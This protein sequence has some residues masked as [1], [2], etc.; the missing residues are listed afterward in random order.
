M[1]SNKNGGFGVLVRWRLA[2]AVVLLSALSAATCEFA[3]AQ[4]TYTVTDLGTLGGTFGAANGINNKGWVDGMANLPGDANH[5][6]L[7]WVQGLKIDLGTLGGPNSM[8]GLGPNMNGKIVGLAE[9][10]IPDPN[11]EDFC[12]CGTH[13]ICLPFLWQN[14]VMAPLPTLGGNNG[15]A[16]DINNQG[17]VVGV[18]ETATPDSTCSVSQ[19]QGEAFLWEKG[20][21]KELP[22][23]PGDP[24][25]AALSINDKGQA[26]GASGTCQIPFAG[27]PFHALLWENGVATDLGNLGGAMGHGANKINNRGQVVG[28]SDLPGDT[29]AHAFLWQNGVMTDLG[30]VPGDFLSVG[31]GINDKAQVVGLSCDINF[32]CRAFLWQNGVMTDLNTLIPTG[33]PL[34]LFIANDINARGEIVGAA[35]LPSTGEV[36]AFLATPTP[37]GSA[38]EA[39]KVAL[40]ENVRSHSSKLRLGRFGAGLM[41][42][43]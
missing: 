43:R 35:F 21:L 6:A 20:E 5:H 34:F 4:V 30:T 9:T 11:G 3:A 7:L 33:S 2:R 36:H 22:P 37:G 15:A 18:A 17:Q 14:G 27:V 12:L 1:K 8:S 31:F 39:P 23:F 19:N 25:G 10:S 40:P 16:S 38:R 13:L 26:A 24:D 42:P 32:N 28:F 29:T 41:R